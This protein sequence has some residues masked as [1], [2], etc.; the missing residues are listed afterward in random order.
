[1]I[2]VAKAL[3]KDFSFVR[4]DLYS[5]RGETYFSELTFYPNGGFATFYPMEWEYKIGEWLKL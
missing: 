2:E 4:V 5:I 1:M 3:A